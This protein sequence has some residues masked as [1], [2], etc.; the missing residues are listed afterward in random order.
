MGGVMK[1]LVVDDDINQIRLV[2]ERFT[3]QGHEV[4]EAINGE[5]GL[6]V[7]LVEK[8]DV[9]LLDVMMPVMNGWELCKYLRN[10]REFDDV[11]IIML[12]A[13]GP[14]LNEMTSPLYGADDYV[15]K[16]FLFSELEEKMQKSVSTRK[17]K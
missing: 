9:I 1:I 12:T 5:E 14:N 6:E 3:K 17:R 13:I 8:P 16:P 10:K 11:A 4:L 2:R 15:D 7:A